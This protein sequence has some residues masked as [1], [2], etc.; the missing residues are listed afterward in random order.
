[1]KKLARI[2]ALLGLLL[3]V[4]CIREAVDP[5]MSEHLPAGT[6]V[7]MRIGFG[8]PDIYE[9]QI[10]TKAESARTDEARVHDLYVMVFDDGGDK[11]YGR[12]F[13]YEHLIGSLQT[14]DSNS[15]EGWYVENSENSRGVVKI[16]TQAQENAT[17][18]VLANVLNS[19][20]TLTTPTLAEGL[21]AVDCLSRISTLE[22]LKQVRVELQQQIVDRSDFFLMMG[23]AEDI[24]TGDY[25]WGS[26]D[27]STPNYKKTDDGKYQIQLATLD[28]K[29]KF[30]IKYDE[31]LINRQR[32]TPRNWWVYNVPS[33]SYL[34]PN[35]GNPE[36]TSYF[37]TDEAYFEGEQQI[38]GTVYQVFSF[39]MIENRQTA[40]SSIEVLTTPNYYLRELQ[41]KDYD[42][43]E[44][45]GPWVYAPANGTYV[46]FDVVLG[47]TTDGIQS[48]LD[49]QNVNHALTSEAL[50]TVHL[51][52]FTSSEGG[53]HDYD[54]YSVERS[55]AY[56]YYITIENSKKIYVEVKS[57]QGKREDEPGQ[58]GS[59]LLATDEIVNCDA[60]YEYHSLTFKYSE[61][62]KEKGVSWYV[63][64]PFSEGGA[65]WNG[66]DWDFD[67]EDYLWVKFGVNFVTGGDYTDDRH[68][69]PGDFAYNPNWNPGGEAYP[70]GFWNSL[71]EE[72]RSSLNSIFATRGVTR[73]T[74]TYPELM[75]IHQLI[76]YI[77]YQTGLNKEGESDFKNNVIRVTAFIDEYYYEKDPR[78]GA[79]A[80]A[81]PDLWRT[82]VNAKPRELH[83]LSDA[84]LSADRHSDV[85]TS[86]HSIIQQSIQTFYNIYSPDLTSLWGTEHLDEMSYYNRVDK[87][88][89][90]QEA[91]SWWPSGRKVP[92][93]T[94]NNEE[95]G[96]V[97]TATL[98]GLN[99][100]SAPGWD[101]FLDYDV[102]NM[103]PELQNDYKYLA[104][105]CLT[106]N[107]DNDGDN[108]IDPEEVRWYIASA[109]QIVGM[110]VGNES[111][112]P[113]ARIYQPRNAA[114][115]SNG[116]DWRSWV[117]SSTDAGDDI[118]KMVI[119]R[120]EE[121]CTKSFYD[122]FSWAGFD[123]TQRDMVT[124]IRCVRNIGTFQSN[125]ETTDIS[126]APYDHQVDEYYE[127]AAGVDANGKALPNADGTY[128]V[129]FSRLNPKS[130]REYTSDDLP[131]H[132]EYSQHN[133]V[134]LEL[135]MQSRDNY[136]YADGSFPAEDEEVVNNNI[137]SS[138]HNSY[139]PTGYRLPNMTEL[140]LM[141]ALQPSSYWSSSKFYPCR[142]YYS[143]GA[144]GKQITGEA[145]KVGWAYSVS[146]GRV[147]MINQNVSLTGVRCV[148]D[149]NCIGEITGKIMVPDGQNLHVGEDMTIKLNFTSQG[150]A[151]KNLALALVYVGTDGREYTR[152][153]DV[154]SVKLSGVSLRD[155]LEYT[156]PSDLPLLGSMSIRATVRNSAGIT[157]T[158][159]APIKVLSPVFASVR[160]LPCEYNLTN[161]TKDNPSFPVLVTASSPNSTITGWK[162]S[163]KDPEGVTEV[164]NLLADGRDSHYWSSITHY[165]YELNNLIRGTYTFQLDVT[166][167]DGTTRS[168][169]ASMDILRVNYQPN[170]GTTGPTGDYQK[171]TDITTLWEAERVDN[172]NF[173]GGDFIEANMDV[174][175]CTYMAVYDN[176]EPPKR[177]D[178]L[179]IGRDNLISVGITGT[180]AAVKAMTLP[181]VYNIYFP[182]HDGGDSSGQDWVRPNITKGEGSNTSNGTNYKLFKSGPGTGFVLQSGSYYKPDI[183]KRQ[184]FRLERSGGFW[185]GQLMDTDNWNE[186]GQDG[187]PS[188]AAASLERILNSGTVYV[189]STQGIHHSRARYCFV[190]AV[191]N[192]SSSNAAGGE[193]GFVSDPINGGNL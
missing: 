157:R 89:D 28:A 70:D 25:V 24:D 139:C 155:E 135:N 12:Y 40:R 144:V 111:L 71:T 149:E 6:P 14:L 87:D 65:Q 80:P 83:I 63:K 42:A 172:I 35:A 108:V 151:I 20:T 170:P 138:G 59:L 127:V 180:G 55:H 186:G 167:A 132:Q 169:V 62:I 61:D 95:N 116:L 52:D 57:D 158:F 109:N 92:S 131:Y 93:G 9:V 68:V 156:I 173:H 72:E 86:S 174:S 58:E 165:D 99:S 82:F 97:N 110:W 36:E 85:I 4:S 129:R 18:V 76:K 145:Q 19:I 90:H 8:I 41:E 26:L 3:P 103:T 74:A 10:G 54:N 88:P 101:T 177:V 190:R 178:D 114:N 148:R 185:N 143:Y 146:S 142:T 69:Y 39:Y 60:H 30:Y 44:V 159:E 166:T 188:E 141:V 104:Y 78:L 81:D 150:S 15:N 119:I 171:A 53:T 154:S 162:L 121:G 100:G 98:W 123:A 192:S 122:E 32:S 113:S 77:F 126:Y 47:L 38:D 27:G 21:D 137:T 31:T 96:R 147:N 152:D 1:M 49:D 29:V 184:H 175:T 112:S 13:T 17:L 105:S 75:D 160:L 183:T 7:T 94:K 153:I 33:M 23:L 118:N 102:D 117:L 66:S 107:R 46:Q 179:S 133:K 34:F 134:Y 176:S 130:I 5:A 11:I 79:D 164:F 2:I 22:E 120:A 136:K 168:E 43:S 64:T 51:G 106:R 140:L 37:D 73:E 128:T 67:C 124:S 163:V 193:T 48:I 181:N 50:Y 84:Q 91:W 182:A 187:S 45:N 125:G 56:T 191:R 189:G 115:T 16:A 161:E